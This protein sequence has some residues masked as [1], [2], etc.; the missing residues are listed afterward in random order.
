LHRGFASDEETGEEGVNDT[1]RKVAR[2]GKQQE[3]SKR[4]MKN[5]RL[6]VYVKASN[7]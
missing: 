2:S 7:K 6:S 1:R 5:V 4:D 3:G